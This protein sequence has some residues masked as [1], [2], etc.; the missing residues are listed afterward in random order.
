MIKALEE[1]KDKLEK[2]SSP[3][4]LE[5]VKDI[6]KYAKKKK[7]ALY[8]G[9]FLT[10]AG[11]EMLDMWW[12]TT[13]Q[14]EFLAKHFAHHMTI[15]FK[16]SVE[17]VVSLPIGEGVTLKIIGYGEDERGQAVMVSGVRSSNEIPH[18]TVSTAEGISPV[19]SNE[20]L[21]LGITEVDGPELDARIGFHNG[22]EVRYDFEGSIYE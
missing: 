8:I 7:K 20:L 14:K 5:S 22:K 16:P 10:P 2:E 19:Y 6:I 17:E 1:L 12:G 9:A 3:E 4:Y 11:A 15:K 18:I 21:G 13:V